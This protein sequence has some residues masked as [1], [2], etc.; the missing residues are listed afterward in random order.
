MI[1]LKGDVDSFCEGLM[2]APCQDCISMKCGPH[3]R[4]VYLFEIQTLFKKQVVNMVCYEGDAKL[5]PTSHETL[6]ME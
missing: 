2:L 3:S 5:S 1:K 6:M 4:L